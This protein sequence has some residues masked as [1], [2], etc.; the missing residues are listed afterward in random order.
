MTRS[1][2]P[3]ARFV[4]LEKSLAPHVRRLMA[5]P[6]YGELHSLDDIRVLMESHVY[7][8]WDFMS[9]VKALQIELT[10]VRVPWLPPAEARLARFLNEIVLGEESDDLGDGLCLSHCG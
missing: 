5:H 9:L 6:L 2:S 1:F 8:V 7:A 4:K 10:S 3:Q